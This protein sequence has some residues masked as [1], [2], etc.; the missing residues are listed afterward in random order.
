MQSIQELYDKRAKSYD[1]LISKTPH[2]NFIEKSINTIKIN[3]K[4]LKVLD[5]GCGTGFSSK[6]I[7]NKYPLS[8]ITGLDLSK[9]MLA[10]FSK[11]LP[12][13]KTIAGDF[14]SPKVQTKLKKNSF[15]LVISTGTLSEY[16]NIEESVPI[17]YSLLK[18][19]GLFL[20]I[21][22]KKNIYSTISGLFWNY[23]P[24]GKNKIIKECKKSGFS[25]VDLILESYS[26]FGIIATK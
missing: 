3:K 12:L 10:I 18:K 25:K 9:E 7:L 13:S 23:K 26:R 15:D 4:S 21:G 6:F 16:L 11:N 24:A 19:R 8:E 20:N 17:V 14:S 5:L 22:L 1:S 2:C